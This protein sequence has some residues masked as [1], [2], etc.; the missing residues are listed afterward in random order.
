MTVEG[1]TVA[2]IDAF[3]N[4]QPISAPPLSSIAVP[5]LLP[6]QKFI[7]FDAKFD[8]YFMMCQILPEEGLRS[9]MRKDGLS[10]SEVDNFIREAYGP[11]KGNELS[12]I[13]L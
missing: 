13:V 7:E 1:F 9:K 4:P 3:F 6:Q 12:S 11:N 2:E 8:K 10:S 5:T